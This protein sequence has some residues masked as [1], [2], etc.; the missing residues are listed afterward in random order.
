MSDITLSSGEM[1]Q[2]LGYVGTVVFGVWKMSNTVA[3]FKAALLSQFASLSTEVKLLQQAHNNSAAGLEHRF[4]NIAGAIEQQR[5]QLS[6]L[7][8]QVDAISREVV[9]VKAREGVEQKARG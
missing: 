4:G 6:R 8:S 2:L 1:L 9:E 3:E 7:Q 5:E